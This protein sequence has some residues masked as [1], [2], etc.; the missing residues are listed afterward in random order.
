MKLKEILKLLWPLQL[1]QESW[2][3]RK[4]EDMLTT[5]EESNF[6]DILQFLHV[7]LPKGIHW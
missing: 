2:K 4:K 5:Q 7:L 3:E 1:E 6:S